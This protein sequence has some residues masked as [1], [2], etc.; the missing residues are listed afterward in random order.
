M[1]SRGR[2]KKK[3][4]EQLVRQQLLTATA[5][6]LAEKSYRAVSIREI[7]ERADSNSAMVAY[8]FKN[9]E[10]LVAELLQQRIGQGLT[11]EQAMAALASLPADQRSKQV[12]QSF[13]ELYRQHPWLMKLVVDDMVNEDSALRGLMVDGI[14]NGSAELLADFIALQQRQGY[15]RQDINP[16][17][18]RASLLS[19]LSFPFLASPILGD[20]Y[21]L[22]MDAVDMTQ[23]IEH[24]VKFFEASLLA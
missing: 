16:V 18:V 22:D 7:A 6:C 1:S 4:D 11:S 23:W 21:A 17:F 2:P 10:G 20:A 12:F 9:K 5:E 3:R 13:I 19:L 15:F 14:A 24:S 8:Y